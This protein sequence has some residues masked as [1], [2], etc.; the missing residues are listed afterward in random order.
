MPE[1]L[2]EDG[3]YFDP[4]DVADIAGTIRGVLRLGPDADRLYRALLRSRAEDILT[5]AATE[6]PLPG[7]EPEAMP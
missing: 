2:G 3:L 1:V 4:R 7:L 6:P 5:R